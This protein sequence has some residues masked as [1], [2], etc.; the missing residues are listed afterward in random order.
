MRRAATAWSRVDDFFA[1]GPASPRLHARSGHRRRSP[2]ATGARAG[3]RS[4]TRRSRRRRYRY[5]GGAIGNVARG[6]RHQASRDGLRGVK[7]VTN[8][9][10]AARRLATPRRWTTAS[11][12]RRT[13]SDARPRGHRRGLRRPR[14]CARRAWR[15]TRPTR[16]RAARSARTARSSRR[17]ARSRCVVLPAN[18]QPTP[19]PSEASCARSAAGWSRAG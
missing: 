2:S 3:S 9:R 11:S 1:P 12:A 14:R 13:T 6:A 5:G 7:G 17:T 4:P 15:C 8:L 19:Q 10:A 16:C 18:D